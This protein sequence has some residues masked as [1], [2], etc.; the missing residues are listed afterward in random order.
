[1]DYVLGVHLYRQCL[2]SL[3]AQ[4]GA[5]MKK[6]L[7]EVSTAWS[8]LVHLCA[9]RE[10]VRIQR[11][12]RGCRLTWLQRSWVMTARSAPSARW[13]S[14]SLF[15]TSRSWIVTLNR[16]EEHK[17][18]VSFHGASRTWSTTSVVN[19]MLWSSYFLGDVD[20]QHTR[21]TPPRECSVIFQL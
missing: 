3:C 6:K 21:L 4:Y 8:Q 18:P 12:C 5:T 1:M 10:R 20:Y 14:L 16:N 13:K 15:S 19:A 11:V 17:L 9:A 2:S 7:N